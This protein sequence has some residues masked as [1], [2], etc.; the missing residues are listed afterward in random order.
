MKHASDR[1]LL[2]LLSAGPPGQGELA[3]HLD[4]CPECRSRLERFAG[5]W[6]ILGRVDTTAVPADLAGRITRAVERQDQ[7]PSRGVLARLWQ[8]AGPIGRVA[9]AVLAAS[10]VGF[11]LGRFSGTAPSPDGAASHT[12]TQTEAARA[13]YLDQI[14]TP[15]VG[16]GDAL[17]I[18]YL[19][20]LEE[21][22]R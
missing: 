12:V 18:S 4:V 20:E 6:E 15:S 1:Q 7:A 9:A 2:D 14:C 11:A 5:T 21:Q 10:A 3:R 17:S 19:P 8:S 22:E 16:L 13:V